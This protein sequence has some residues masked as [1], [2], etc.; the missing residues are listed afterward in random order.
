MQGYVESGDAPGMVI[1]ILR[2][3]RA[4]YHEAFGRADI[5][6]GAPMER[7]AIFRIA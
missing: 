3:G 6:S 5:E 2:D 4:V 7:D 1:L